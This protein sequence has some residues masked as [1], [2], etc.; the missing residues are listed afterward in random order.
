MKRSTDRI[1]TTHPGRLPDPPNRDAVMEARDRDD[2]QAFDAG[3]RTR[4][5]RDDREAARSRHRPHERWRV[6]EG[7]ATRSTTTRAS[8][9]STSMPLQPG[10]SPSLLTHDLR[11]RTSPEFKAFYEA[12]D[13]V[14]NAPMPGGLVNPP[15]SCALGHRPDELSLLVAVQGGE[16][17]RSRARLRLVKGAI[18]A[19]GRR[20][21]RTSS[22]PV[23]GPGWLDHFVRDEHYRNEEEYC[24][25]LALVARPTSRPSSTRASSCRWTTRGSRPLGLPT[26]RPSVRRL[27]RAGAATHR[28]HEL[29]AGGHSGGSAC[30][31][32][33]AGAAGTAPLSDLR[34][35]DVGR[36][37]A[38][39]QRARPTPSR[40]PT[41]RHSLRL[42]ACGRTSSC[43]R[44]RCSFPASSRTPRRRSSLRSR[45]PTAW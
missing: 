26:R 35:R 30:A 31:I 39:R 29:G 17:R 23:L 28:G 27:S 33:S 19:A 25:A 21:S 40:R 9:A 8:P 42:A 11:E 16:P 10:Q 3:L 15:A 1:L 38:P 2:R 32:T 20:R 44:A 37:D 45:W 14:G 18:E 6:L 36:P 13:R 24:Q 43:R 34:L 4:A 7:P 12:F 5:W 22:I 41:P